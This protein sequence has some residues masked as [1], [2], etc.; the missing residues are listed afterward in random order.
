MIDNYNKA[1]PTINCP[2]CR[3]GNTAGPNCRRCS[4]D[5]SLL[6][7]LEGDRDSLMAIAGYRLSTGEVPAALCLLARAESLRPG[8]DV[9]RLRAV[10]NVLNLDY[11]TAIQ[12]HRLA[13]R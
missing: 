9:H 7:R 5:M 12:N 10:A 2:C 4:A 11:R 3:A 1:M 6:F 8:E 13:T